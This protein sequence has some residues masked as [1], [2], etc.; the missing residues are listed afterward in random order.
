MYRTA[1]ILSIFYS[2]TECANLQRYDS[3]DRYP[4]STINNLNNQFPFKTGS[5]GND[6]ANFPEVTR[7]PNYSPSYSQSYSP[8]YNSGYST[9]SRYPNYNNN[10]N[11]GYSTNNY[12]TLYSGG[13][14]NVNYNQGYNIQ[15][16]NQRPGLQGGYSSYEA[17]FM[18]DIGGCINRSPQVGISVE[19]LMG[20][21]YGVEL[22][23]H[24]GADSRIDY[25]RTC[26]VVHIAEPMD[27]VSYYYVFL[28]VDEYSSCRLCI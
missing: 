18:R 8:G 28:N 3:T 4:S 20:M 17:P 14:S 24:L 6:I 16:Y 9:T 19:S 13:S 10:Y 15:G 12:N 7:Y 1:T 21:W 5:Y 26:I 23:Q 11:N 22:I 2:I 25:A 27:R